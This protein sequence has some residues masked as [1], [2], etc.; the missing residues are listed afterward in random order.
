MGHLHTL[1][2]AD[3]LSLPISQLANLWGLFARSRLL[4]MEPKC[5]LL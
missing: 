4:Y 5:G 3:T 1:I 2:D